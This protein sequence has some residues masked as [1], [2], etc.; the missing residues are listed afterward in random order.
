VNGQKYHQ[1]GNIQS[2]KEGGWNNSD[3]VVVRNGKKT[4]GQIGRP[5]RMINKRVEKEKTC[6]GKAEEKA[7]TCV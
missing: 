6:K 3:T 1:A 2:G 5:A 4:R 7:M